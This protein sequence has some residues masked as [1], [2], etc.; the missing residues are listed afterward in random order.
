MLF[1]KSNGKF[2]ELKRCDYVNDVE[3]YTAIIRTKGVLSTPNVCNPDDRVLK[4]FK[5]KFARPNAE[6]AR[7]K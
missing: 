1:R 4:A 6:S 2:I 7:R 3:Y 5:N